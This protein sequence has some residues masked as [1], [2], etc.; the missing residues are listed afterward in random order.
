M[1]FNAL[2]NGGSGEEPD[3]SVEDFLKYNYGQTKDLCQA[4]LSVLVPV[5][6]FSVTFSDKLGDVR[7]AP[8]YYKYVMLGSWVCFLLSIIG[9]GL[10]LVVTWLAARRML[11]GRADAR[12]K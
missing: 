10:A 7:S 11:W 6:M 12:T 5:L 4:I 8:W 9:A 1:R 3:K 2:D